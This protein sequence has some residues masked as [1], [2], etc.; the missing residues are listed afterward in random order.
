MT[1]DGT[2]AGYRTLTL[3][4]E[5]TN[6]L[7]DLPPAQ[8]IALTEQRDAQLLIGPDPAPAGGVDIV[9]ESDDP[10]VVEVLTASITIPEGEVEASAKVVGKSATGRAN[11]TASNPGFAPD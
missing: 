9:I 6:R 7:I 1:A 4:F 2:T 3:E 5:I 10:S 8:V 11:L